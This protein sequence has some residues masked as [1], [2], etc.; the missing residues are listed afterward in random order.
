MRKNKVRVFG[1]F[2]INMAPNSQGIAIAG[3]SCVIALILL[4]GVFTPLYVVSDDDLN[5][6]NDLLKYKKYK[7]Q[8]ICTLI[9]YNITD[10]SYKTPEKCSF[11]WLLLN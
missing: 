3:T 7:N 2:N 5:K 4:V 9:E 8:Y 10:C 1:N 11:T 6:S